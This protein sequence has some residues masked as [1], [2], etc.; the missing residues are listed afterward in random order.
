MYIPRIYQANNFQ[1]GNTL[2]LS[3]EAANHLTRVLRLRVD[4]KFILFNGRGGE[5]A[6]SIVVIHKNEVVAKIEQFTPKDIE[7]Q[8]YLHLGQGISRGEKMDY[9]IQKA[10]E[11]GVKKISPLIT[12]HCGVK[13]ST[14]RWN[15]KLQHWQT[16]AIAACEQCGR[17]EIPLITE[18][19]ILTS[20]L[21]NLDADLKF[22]C[23]PGATVSL[24]SYQ[25]QVKSVALL[26]G[27]ES[28]FTEAE[29][30][31]AQQN[32][33]NLLKLGPRI[34]RTE[35]AAIAAMTAMQVH[36]GDMG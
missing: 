5:F 14:E 6:A 31:L 25:E 12:E 33:C 10:T 9:V 28:G 16:V 7:S 22:I 20:W 2:T 23:D 30:Y 26:I 24:N 35:T 1:L 29:I 8:L 32:G 13:L 36:F 19:M 17:N 15:K 11:L 3:R 34:L 21:N 4:D 27:P 18:P